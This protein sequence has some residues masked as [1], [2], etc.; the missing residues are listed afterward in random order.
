MAVINIVFIYSRA[1]AGSIFF[2]GGGGGG[3]LLSET[4]IQLETAH[5]VN[6]TQTLHKLSITVQWMINCIYCG[7]NVK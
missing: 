5:N 2:W 7:Q 3:G 6:V 4:E 1:K